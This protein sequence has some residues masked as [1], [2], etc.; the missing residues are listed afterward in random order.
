MGVLSKTR[1]FF[2][3]LSI[4]AGPLE[5]F[6]F[7]R[8]RH[9]SSKC[10][11]TVELKL[12]ELP[13]SPVTLRSKTS[14]STVFLDVFWRKF[15]MPPLTLNKNS[16]ILDLGANIGLTMVD[17][18]IRY[19]HSRIVGVELDAQN[20][21]LAIQNTRFMGSRCEVIHAGIWYEDGEISYSDDCEEWGYRV[22]DHTGKPHKT[23]LTAPGFTV[24]T[25]MK[26]LNL[27]KIDFVKMDI[28]GA[29]NKVIHKGAKWLNSVNSLNIEIHTP[30]TYESCVKVLEPMGFDCDR[31][32]VHSMG[33]LAKRRIKKNYRKPT[34]LAPLSQSSS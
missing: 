11:D 20:A 34:S 1:W 3:Y 13:L 32:T 29:E 10:P 16:V 33:L 23:S 31:S 30:A 9:N 17:L 26:R 7:R 6:K 25:L 27:N 4:F 2:R 28:E 8:L 18:G 12:R 22:T 14:D 15:H 24:D 19:P 5:V 21:A